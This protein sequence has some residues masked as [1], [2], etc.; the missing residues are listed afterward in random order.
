MSR[1]RNERADRLG[2]VL[3]HQTAELITMTLDHINT[4]IRH[5]SAYPS[6]GGDQLGISG[7]GLCVFVP[8]DEHGPDERIAVTTIEAGVMRADELREVR[9]QL[10]DRLEGIEV[11]VIALNKLMR[12][13]LGTRVPRTLPELCDGKAKGYSGHM[14]AWIPYGRD[15][16]NGWHDPS[17]R[18]AAGAT[19]LCDPCLIRMNRWR[20]RNG[21]PRIASDVRSEVVGRLIDVA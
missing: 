11:A 8:Q 4:E 19:G 15:E 12:R 7:G 2:W 14:L 20:E 18:D 9:E 16:T 6:G 13:T 10:R 3:Q 21:L 1:P 17:C 5:L